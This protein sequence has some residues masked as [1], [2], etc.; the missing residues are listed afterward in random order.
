VLVIAA[1]PPPPY[2]THVMREE[3]GRELKQGR[4]E[5]VA[6]GHHLHMEQPSLVGDLVRGGL[7]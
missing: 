1:D 7:V 3:R 5:V 6:G 2:F 4:C